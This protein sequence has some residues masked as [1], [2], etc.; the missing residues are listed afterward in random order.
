MSKNRSWLKKSIE[1]VLLPEL[2]RRGYTPAP[3]KPEEKRGEIGAA[4][5]FGRLRRS[6]PR[7]LEMV[8][9]QL[10]KHGGAA[11]RLNLG[12]APIQ[13]VTGLLVAHILQQDVRVHYLDR[14]WELLKYPRLWKWFSVWRWPGTPKT[15]AD[16]DELVTK[17]VALL[18]EVEALF[19]EGK[20]GPHLRE[21]N[22]TQ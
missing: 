17:V 15:K 20:R 7:G 1:T 3:V 12:I 4:F 21:V 10:D 14:S 18:P 11:F 19:R 2:E 9:I 6:G 22:R 16:Y 8:E 5:P 13:G